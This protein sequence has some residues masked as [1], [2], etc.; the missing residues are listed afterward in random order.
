M[1]KNEK[2]VHKGFGFYLFLFILI[3][4]AAFM[5][6]VTVMMFSPKKVILGYQYFTY[7]DE[8]EV[9]KYTNTEEEQ[10][11]KFNELNRIVINCNSAAVNFEKTNQVKEDTVIVTNKTSGFAKKNQNV[12]FKYSVVYGET[13]NVK[14]MTINLTETQS[15]LRFTNDVKVT[16]RVPI[17]SEYNFKTT[18]LVVTTTGGA[19]TVGNVNAPSDSTQNGNLDIDNISIST[20]SGN[21]KFTKFND[22][23]F[24]NLSL[25]TGSGSFTTDLEEI[26]VQT[27]RVVTN[28]GKFTFKNIKSA[29]PLGLN[30]GDGRLKI[31]TLTGSLSLVAHNANV[32]ITNLTG[33]FSANETIDLINKSTIF[34]EEVG[35]DVSIPYAKASNL[36]FNKVAGNINIK[37]SS[38]NVNVGEKA[39]I[40]KI[41][42]IETESGKIVAKVGY[43][44]ATVKHN[45]ITKSGKVELDYESL[46]GANYINSQSGEVVVTFK[47]NS[48]FLL[49]L[50]KADGTEY[51][52]LEDKLNLTFID[53]SQYAYP[54]VVNGYT[55]EINFLD[56]QT[57]GKITAQLQEIPQE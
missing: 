47:S 5:I 2:M 7:S 27:G 10:A 35:G 20:K 36:T 57:G 55:G 53:A 21:I 46:G 19:V 49:R 6:I 26:D 12:D 43:T 30:L 39:A 11:I 8:Y 44:D 56:V 37:T 16:I 33:D 31:D 41:I 1:A 3:L 14:V 48:Q 23:T 17:T 32:N 18:E 29:Q 45:F 50:R 24:N 25:N 28:S 54:L 51:K 15:F 13:N 38:G 4:F 9:S 34:V 52:K 42:S 22:S 40:S